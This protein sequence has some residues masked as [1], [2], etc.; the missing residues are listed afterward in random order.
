M[1]TAFSRVAETCS[2]NRTG[3][4]PIRDQ[5]TEP[6]YSFAQGPLKR[7]GAA[8]LVTLGAFF[9]GTGQTSLLG[10]QPTSPTPKTSP[11]VQKPARKPVLDRR[12]VVIRP[13]HHFTL[14]S[15]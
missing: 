11:S 2:R 12:Q 1:V 6:V 15:A 4:P 14:R 3:D 5:T 9:S 8:F 10:Y 7:L 13:D